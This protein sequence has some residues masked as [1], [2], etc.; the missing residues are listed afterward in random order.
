[1]ARLRDIKIGKTVWIKEGKTPIDVFAT[2]CE[3]SVSKNIGCKA[4][5]DD[6]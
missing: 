5:G 4:V 2:D 6:V 3:V 1:M